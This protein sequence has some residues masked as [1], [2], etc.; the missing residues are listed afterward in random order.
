MDGQGNLE[1]LP[2]APQPGKGRSSNIGSMASAIPTPQLGDEQ[3]SLNALV[4][5]KRTKVLASM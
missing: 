1:G 5:G 4:Y 2:A 3:T